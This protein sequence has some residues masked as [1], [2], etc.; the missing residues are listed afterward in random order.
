AG[1]DPGAERARAHRADEVPFDSATKY[2]VTLHPSGPNESIVVVKGA[3]DVVLARCATVVGP[4]E[5]LPLDAPVRSQV[6][7]ANTALGAQGLRV[8]AVATRTLPVAVGDYA[9]DLAAEVS[10]LQLEMLVGILDPARPE[11]VAGI[12]ECH[13]AGIAVKMITGDH[14]STA[15]AIAAQLGID[16]RVVTGADLDALSD[17]DLAEAIDEI[18][19]CARV[20]PQ[21]K[22]RVVTALQ[23]RGQV[24][25]MT[26]DGVNDAASLRQAEIGVAMGI[27]GTEVTKEAGDMIL[28]DDNFATIVHAVER[29][30]AIYDNIVTF[31]RFQLTT[32][33]AALSTILL[34][35]LLGYPALFNPVQVLFVNIIA[36]GPPAMSLGVDP[37]KPGVMDRAPRHRGERILSGSR[38]GRISWTAAVMVAITL[39]VFLTHVETTDRMDLTDPAYTLAFTTFVFLQ[40]LNALCVR[41]GNLSLFNRYTFTNRPLLLSLGAVIVMQ[42]AIVELSVFR[43][44]FDTVHLSGAEWRVAALSPLALVAVEE[45]RKL[46][47]RLLGRSASD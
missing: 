36:D 10:D 21:H 11:A 33:I 44:I 34:T 22:V 16:G 40:M 28:A 25:A 14:A 13:R 45:F 9:G 3:P 29:G 2:M 1:L 24:V 8:L 17:D 23:S 31:V 39:G 47:V 37:P 42:V 20:S 27:T 43:S 7:A 18:G 12:A 4:A 26:G 30:R 19:V 35:R 5:L 15:G 46:G 32:N 6:D 38:L 41:S